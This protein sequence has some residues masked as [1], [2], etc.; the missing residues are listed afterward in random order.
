LLLL[1]KN[2]FAVAQG[3]QKKMNFWAIITVVIVVASID[4]AVSALQDPKDRVEPFKN[5]VWNQLSSNAE[6]AHKRTEGGKKQIMCVGKYCKNITFNGPIFVM[7]DTGIFG[8]LLWAPDFEF[9]RDSFYIQKVDIVCEHYYSDEDPLILK[10][11]CY[12]LLEFDAIKDV[13][14]NHPYD[15]FPLEHIKCNPVDGCEYHKTDTIVK[16]HTFECWHA[17]PK[18]ETDCWDVSSIFGKSTGQKCARIDDVKCES[19]N[20]YYYYHVHTDSET[21]VVSKCWHSLGRDKSEASAITH[22]LVGIG[23]GLPWLYGIVTFVVLLQRL[24]L[25]QFIAYLRAS[26]SQVEPVPSESPPESK[27]ETEEKEKEKVPRRKRRYSKRSSRPRNGYG[28]PLVEGLKTF[29]SR[30][31]FIILPPLLFYP[32]KF[33]FDLF[34]HFF[35]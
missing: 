35:T 2:K 25:D 24:G 20:C 26:F 22:V 34:F 31:L 15:C 8:W 7:Y 30:I 16:G 18:V 12:A 5:G 1:K 13:L 4:R 3:Q 29:G 21:G 9:A 28:F 33:I 27:S 14:P 17:T 32:L 10:D 6:V 11:S 19:K 23:F